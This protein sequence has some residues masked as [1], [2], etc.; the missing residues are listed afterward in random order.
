YNMIG[1]KLFYFAIFALICVS[2]GKE[3]LL[4]RGGHRELLGEERTAAINNLKAALAKLATGDGPSYTTV[5]VTKVTTQVVAGS[6]DTYTVELQNGGVSKQCVV[7]IW[8]QPWIE[9]NGTNIKIECAG[10]NAKVD[11][12]W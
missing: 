7:R 5:S 10:D 3:T 12:S 1:S 9:V 6:L 8:S 4:P 11:S 2:L